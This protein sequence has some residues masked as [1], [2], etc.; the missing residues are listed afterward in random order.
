MCIRDSYHASLLANV[1][2][3]VA[4]AV[5]TFVIRERPIEALPVPAGRTPELAGATSSVVGD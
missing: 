3:G 4:A 1:A 2:M 5:A